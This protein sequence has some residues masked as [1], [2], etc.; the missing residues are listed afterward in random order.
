M[1]SEPRRLPQ[2]VHSRCCQLLP[3]S[4]H[5]PGT[6]KRIGNMHDQLIACGFKTRPIVKPMAKILI[7]NG[8]ADC[9][10]RCVIGWHRRRRL[11]DIQ[12]V[13]G[14]PTPNRISAQMTLSVIRGLR[15]A[16]P[17]SEPPRNLE[18]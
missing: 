7:A 6:D 18:P 16:T 3:E 11:L 15:H 2:K 17:P 14:V 10:S 13:A 9:F 4:F 5:D 8:K 12:M 1:D